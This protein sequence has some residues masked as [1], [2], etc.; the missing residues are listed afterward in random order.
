MTIIS[1]MGRLEAV[2]IIIGNIGLSDINTLEGSLTNDVSKAINILDEETRNVM[3]EGWH[4][5]TEHDVPLA[6]DENNE[7]LWPDSYASIDLEPKNNPGTADIIKRNGKI[8]DKAN[9]SYT[10]DST[11]K[12]TVIE[13]I[14]W[15]DLPQS[16]RAYIAIKAART[17]ADRTVGSGEID[18]LTR[19]DEMRAR[20]T[21]MDDEAAQAD[22]NILETSIPAQVLRRTQGSYFHYNR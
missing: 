11:L 22:Y 3:A 18:A 16:A 12:V 15:T 5:N 10:W 7:I 9:R 2:N 20:S 14:S 8:Y 1:D 13:Y 6:P 21:L 17:Y 19:D 4:F